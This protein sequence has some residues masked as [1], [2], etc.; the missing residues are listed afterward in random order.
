MEEYEK[1]RAALKPMSELESGE[2]SGEEKGLTDIEIVE[3][4]LGIKNG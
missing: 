1:I 3:R 4:M 2:R